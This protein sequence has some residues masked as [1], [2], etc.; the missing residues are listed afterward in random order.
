MDW[1]PH[2]NTEN[3]NYVRG[4]PLLLLGVQAC[5]VGYNEMTMM[6]ETGGKQWK[7]PR[8]QCSPPPPPTLLLEVILLSI[9]SATGI[10][11]RSKHIALHSLA[12]S[13]ALLYHD[14]YECVCIAI[15][16]LAATTT[17]QP[18]RSMIVCWRWSL[19][20]LLHDEGSMAG[21]VAT[22]FHLFGIDRGMNA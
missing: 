2:M 22:C 17:A 11:L 5:I 14:M 20:L 6:T 3:G 4:W 8:K 10:E 18:R 19:L 12:T 21:Y 13:M 9:Y 16:C 1:S 7:S 15:L